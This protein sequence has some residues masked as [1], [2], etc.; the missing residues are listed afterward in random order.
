MMESREK[1]RVEKPRLPRS[2]QRATKRRMEQELGE[3]GIEMDSDDDQVKD[4]YYVDFVF[5]P[6]AWKVRQ[7]F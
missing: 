2:A 3:L 4:L 1:R 7:G 5:M 6:P